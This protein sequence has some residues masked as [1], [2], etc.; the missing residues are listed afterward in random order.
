MGDHTLRLGGKRKRKKKRY[1][2]K[3]RT[4]SFCQKGEEDWIKEEEQYLTIRADGRPYIA[5]YA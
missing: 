1:R 3:L 2:K 4:Q 5:E